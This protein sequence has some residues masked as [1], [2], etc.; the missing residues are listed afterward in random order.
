MTT[1][2]VYPIHNVLLYNGATIAH[3]ALGAFGIA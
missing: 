2:R 1:Y 3:C